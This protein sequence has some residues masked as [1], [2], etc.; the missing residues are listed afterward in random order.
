L[1]AGPRDIIAIVEGIGFDASLFKR[2]LQSGSDY[3][4]QREEIRKWRNS[5]LVGQPFHFQFCRAKLNHRLH[6][7]PPPPHTQKKSG[8]DL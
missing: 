5:F 2:D 4:N 7:P 6:S 8:N 3:L 1:V